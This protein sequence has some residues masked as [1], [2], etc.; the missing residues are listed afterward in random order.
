VAKPS[1]STVHYLPK[2]NGHIEKNSASRRRSRR[3]G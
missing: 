2:P 1:A 3:L